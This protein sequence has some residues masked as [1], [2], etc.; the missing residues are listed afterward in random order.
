MATRRATSSSGSRLSGWVDRD[1]L[2]AFDVRPEPL[3][4]GPS[5]GDDHPRHPLGMAE[6]PEHAQPPPHRLDGRAHPFEGQRLPRREQLHLV[7]ASE[8]GQVG[9]EALGRRAGGGGDEQ[10]VARRA[11]GEAGHGDG[12]GRLGHGQHRVGAPVHE[13]EGG[14]VAQERG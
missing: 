8:L 3:Q 12:A 14:L 4:Q 9:G 6:P 7:F 10:R 11:V 2:H 5:R 1:R 13:P